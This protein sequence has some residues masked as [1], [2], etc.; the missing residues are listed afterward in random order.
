MSEWAFQIKAVNPDGTVTLEFEDY[1]R[2]LGVQ[3]I[4][5]TAATIGD[6]AN[7]VNTVGKRVGKP[8]YDTT[9]NLPLWAAGTGATDTW[10][11]ATGAVS[12]TPV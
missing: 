4:G 1:L 6:A 9:N 10:N 11:D 3:P 5:Y 12:I 2:L 7:E 8:I